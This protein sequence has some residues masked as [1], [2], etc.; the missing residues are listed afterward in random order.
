MS[1]GS[2][3]ES[4]W[5]RGVGETREKLSGARGVERL[6][7]R[8]GESDSHSSLLLVH[9]PRG[10]ELCWRKSIMAERGTSSPRCLSPLEGD[11]EQ[12]QAILALYR[13]LGWDEA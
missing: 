3:R 13:F 11:G 6:I 5:V 9:P 2:A 4:P 10:P 12:I 1:I 8:R 7:A